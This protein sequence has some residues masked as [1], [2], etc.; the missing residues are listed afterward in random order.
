MKRNYRI[1]LFVVAVLFLYFVLG[2][3]VHEMVHVAQA[4]ADPIVKT[5]EFTLGEFR[6]PLKNGTDI[7]LFTI[8]LQPEYPPNA[9]FAEIREIA[10]AYVVHTREVIPKWEA[11]AYLTEWVFIIV[12]AIIVLWKLE[13]LRE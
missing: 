4:A 1:V 3:V 13:W 8:R 9:S 10:E 7:A 12:M 5:N 2:T 11:E 6:N